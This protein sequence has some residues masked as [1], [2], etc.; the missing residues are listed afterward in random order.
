[1]TP[2]CKRGAVVL[3][4]IVN[5][6]GHNVVHQQH[7]PPTNNNNNNS[8]IYLATLGLVGVGG[9]GDEDVVVEDG[10]GDERSESNDE[11]IEW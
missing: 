5:W 1:M 7:P 10:G 2:Y 11:N 3:R 4:C 6:L 9:V 8:N